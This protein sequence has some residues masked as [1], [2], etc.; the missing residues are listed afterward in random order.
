MTI[1]VHN[2]IVFFIC[3]QITYILTYYV[4]IHLRELVD[5]T[6]AVGLCRCL[7]HP[8]RASGQHGVRRRLI[9]WQDL[10]GVF[11]IGHWRL[12]S[13]ISVECIGRGRCEGK[14]LAAPGQIGIRQAV[15]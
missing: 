8:P 13:R 15:R 2:T 14:C 6:A 1:N 12:S 7:V 3:I 9:R 10:Y 11:R 5:V 4:E